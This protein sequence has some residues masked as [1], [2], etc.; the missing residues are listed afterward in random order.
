MEVHC[1]QW[2]V[3]FCFQEYTKTLVKCM[4]PLY[5]ANGYRFL[6][7]I[8]DVEAYMAHYTLECITPLCALNPPPTFYK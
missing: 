2:Q 4:K 5:N 6:F 1:L 8:R 3:D 7:T